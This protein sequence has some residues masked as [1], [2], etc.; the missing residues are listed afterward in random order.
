MK[1]ITAL[2]ALGILA[3][4]TSQDRTYHLAPVI[5]CGDGTGGGYTTTSSNKKLV[6]GP[7][8]HFEILLDVESTSQTDAT[9]TPDISPELSLPLP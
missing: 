2:F 9:N 1:W 3:G 8:I 6:G 5:N 4:C 7:I